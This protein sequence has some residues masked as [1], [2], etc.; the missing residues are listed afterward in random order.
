MPPVSQMDR[1]ALP[2]SPVPGA[3]DGCQAVW[4]VGPSMA[5]V[6]LRRAHLVLGVWLCFVSVRG[7]HLDVTVDCADGSWLQSET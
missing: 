2:S 3:T 7:L 4:G 5:M 1:Q 6:G